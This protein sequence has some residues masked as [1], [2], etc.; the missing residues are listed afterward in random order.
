MTVLTYALGRIIEW[1][2]RGQLKC[3][4]TRAETRFRLSAKQTSPFKSAGAS[5]RSTTGSRGMRISGS[6]AGYTVFRGSAKGTGYPLQFAS[7]PLHFPSRVSPCAITFQLQSTTHI[8]SH[9]WTWWI[10]SDLHVRSINLARILSC[11]VCSHPSSTA[12]IRLIC[13][14][15]YFQNIRQLYWLAC[16]AVWL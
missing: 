15:I 2:I 11:N 12:V 13:H 8:T 7:F 14:R 4:G 5:V 1:G 6:D 16:L 3:E 10:P 9:K